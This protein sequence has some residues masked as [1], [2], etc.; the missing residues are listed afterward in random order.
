M[1]TVGVL[2]IVFAISATVGAAQEPNASQVTLDAKPEPLTLD[3]RH[4]A[5]IVVD[6]QNDF[7]AKGGMFDL[8]GIDISP[9]RKILPST[10]STIEEARKAG[11]KIV[12]LKMAFQPDLS[13]AGPHSAPNWIKHQRLHVGAANRA[14]DGSPSR[15]LVRDTWDTDIVDELKP[16]S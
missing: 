8:A 6:M 2:T 11:I 1:R 3:L 10:A 15:I 7:A 14:P 16:A 13:D 9:I 4:A 5:V 12:Y